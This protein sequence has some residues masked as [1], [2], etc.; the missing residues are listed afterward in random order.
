MGGLDISGPE[1]WH[2][3]PSQAEKLSIIRS[4][5]VQSGI[6]PA[7]CRNQTSVRISANRL[8]LSGGGLQ[9]ENGSL[10]E[11]PAKIVG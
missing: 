5:R 10:A 8:K 4:A 1:L 2:G 9:R 6:L 3:G 11:Q 7:T